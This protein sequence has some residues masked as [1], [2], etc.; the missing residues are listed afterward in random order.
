MRSL[1][2]TIFF[3]FVG[4]LMLAMCI[5][6]GLVYRS[7][8][9][10]TKAQIGQ[11]LEAGWKVFKNELDARRLNQAQ[12]ASLVTQDF[13]LRSE[14]AAFSSQENVES[15][16]V[17]LNNFRERS[18]ANVAIAANHEGH[19]LTATDANFAND[20]AF[21]DSMLVDNGTGTDRLMVKNGQLYHVF[22]NPIYA[23]PPNLLGW[24]ILV[25]AL[26]DQTALNLA[27]ITDLHVSFVQHDGT[28][29]PILA[30]S[31]ASEQRG[32]LNLIDWQ[33]HIDSQELQLAQDQLF[34]LHHLDERQ[35]NG[36]YVI[37]QRSL[38]EAMVGY[39]RLFWQLVIIVILT[40]GFTLFG[41]FVIANQTSKPLST[42]AQYVR[43][44]G[45]GDY[46]LSHTPSTKQQEVQVLFNEF[47]NMRKAIAEREGQIAYAA[48]HDP[49]TDLPN[50]LRFQQLLQAYFN[51]H[52]GQTTAILVLGLNH[53][54]DIN[55]TLGH[56]TGDMLLRQV[57]HRLL[58]KCHPQDEIARFSGDA[59]VVLLT[60]VE[61]NDVL[62]EAMYYK[63]IFD[64]A[65]MVENIAMSI[66][67][68]IGIAIYPDHAEAASTLLQRAEIAM[69]VAKEKRLPCALYT[70]QQNRY[71]LL[72]LS[73]MSELRGAIARGELV[74]FYQPK[75]AIKQGKIISVECLV[76]WQHPVHGMVNPDDFIPLAE[77]TGNIRYLTLWAIDTA[78]AQCQRWQNEG[79]LLDVAVNISSVDLQDASIVDYVQHTLEKYQ[80]APARLALEVT[81]SAVM[82]DIEKAIAMLTQL[83]DMGVRLAI[84][85]YGTGYSSMAQLK[86]LPVDELKI[87]KSFVMDLSHNRDDTIIVRSTIELGHNM[88]LKLVAEGVENQDILTLLGQY[89]CDI[90]QGYGIGRPMPSDKF[91]QWWQQYHLS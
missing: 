27:H 5:N 61:R 55:D 82:L 87:D 2:S 37:L 75:L 8:Y 32:L 62:K 6:F 7:T 66:N 18:A 17:V 88:G 43:R 25:Y 31:L 91:E 47:D 29:T 71:S 59:F 30:S 16:Q 44:I 86:R 79:K 35:D 42:L 40:L 89:Q 11:Q 77:K 74:L 19:I 15:L 1:R 33:P 21:L 13:G 76:R 72:R 78:L 60:D 26:N 14:I 10:H 49:L 56:T 46:G 80:L 68:A 34:L 54:K 84:D 52:Q 4:L 24:F 70:Q 36:L 20:P 85:D 48:Y 57:G 38:S 64:D 39:Q 28:Q 58:A 90:A 3:F 50:R 41:A 67:A 83:H 45:S 65:F 9:I 51:G 73:L 53:F 69:Y 23:P 12:L 63:Q 22:V 81:E